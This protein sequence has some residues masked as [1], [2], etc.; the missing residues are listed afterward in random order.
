MNPDNPL[1]PREA[2]EPS[3]TALL[4]GELPEPQARIVQQALAADPELA[5]RFERLKQTAALIEQT[6]QPQ[7]REP[8]IPPLRLSEARR[9]ELLQ[10][11]KTI[12]PEPFGASVRRRSTWWASAAASIALLMLLTAAFIARLSSSKPQKVVELGRAETEELV[13]R[14]ITDLA[15][16]VEGSEQRGA[17]PDF[18]KQAREQ[19]TL[20]ETFKRSTRSEPGQESKTVDRFAAGTQQIAPSQIPAQPSGPGIPANPP[21]DRAAIALPKEGN[22][23]EV[24][25]FRPSVPSGT[26]AGQSSRSAGV[27]ANSLLEA[28]KD[29]KAVNEQARADLPGLARS[30][31]PSLGDTPQLGALF[32]ARG[33]QQAVSSENDKESARKLR[34]DVLGKKSW[35][36]ETKP[37][38]DVA[39]RRQPD[40]LSETLDARDRADQ[41]PAKAMQT[42]RGDSSATGV[43][44]VEQ[45]TK[46]TALLAPDLDRGAAKPAQQAPTPQPEV[47][48]R[49]Q[50]FSTFSLRVSDVS[51][52]L[53]A[54]SLDQ[55]MLP[56]PNSIR[57]E[58]FIN[59]FDYR[60]PAPSPGQPVAFTWDT[61]RYPFAQN[62]DLVRFSLKTAA[63]GRPVGRPLN[64]VLLLDASG[65][66]ERFDRVQIVHAALRVLATQLHRGDTLSV[67]TFARTARLWVDGVPGDRA[68][69]VADELDGLTPQGGTNLELAMNLGYETALRHYSPAGINR[70]VLLTDGAANLGD[71]D[72]EQLRQMVDKNRR[73]GI[74][75][76]CFG[77][78]WEGYND[79]LLEVLTRAGDGRYGFLNTPEAAATDFAAQLAGA[80]RAAA[81]NVK[82]QVQFNPDRVTSYRQIGF[83]RQQL[84][85]EQFRDNTVV[86][87][88][89]G[90]AEAG[91]ALY[92]IELNDQGSGPIA[93][94]RVRYNIA[95]S[96]EVQEHE[97][98]VPF[99]GQPIAL[100]AAG[101]AMRLAATAGAFAEWLASN[102]SAAEVTPDRLLPYLTGVSAAYGADPNPQK[103]ERMIRQT[104]ALTAK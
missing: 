104:K 74:A 21:A 85:P 56:Q 26:V 83:A 82:V 86:A 46:S 10:T 75:L 16:G 3:L 51:F 62:R 88:T 7:V 8:C 93:V 72:P 1:D 78:G 87:G 48:T 32:Y 97:W 44:S 54:A 94:V 66:M 2:L 52:R 49:E 95:G 57:S 70:V 96:T 30:K 65:S 80:L 20:R 92:V 76:D 15:G 53:A 22:Q 89:L 24:Y 84:A 37:G 50:P 79:D 25:Y 102:P 18:R 40:A 23:E 9:Q 4:L 58:E 27:S 77:I 60:D 13:A 36:L 63:A 73:Q 81:S 43:R 42:G 31:I 47:Q 6:Q 33:K 17:A 12:R 11:F 64:L 39:E 100:E 14:R 101:P 67:V 99:A 69:Q 45:E 55:E 38:S 91:N 61:A 29:E 34:E 71:T 59:A 5:K 103:L 41:K 19:Q 98:I 68:G 28:A 90:A 35:G